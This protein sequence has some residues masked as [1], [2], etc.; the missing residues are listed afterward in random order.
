MKDIKEEL[1]KSRERLCSWIGSLN[2]V[3]IL[4]LLNL[5]YRFNAI[6]IKIPVSYFVDI[7]K[8]IVEFI[9]RGKTPRI[10]NPIMKQK[11]KVGGLILP[12]FKTS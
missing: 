9:S 8:L 10:D 6:P 4:V 1:N 12:E 2:T 7:V 5:I 11:N 3:K